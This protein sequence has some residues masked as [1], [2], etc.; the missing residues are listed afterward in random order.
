M[1][2]A[3]AAAGRRIGNSTLNT[4]RKRHQRDGVERLEGRVLF[5][6]FT[7]N[8]TGGDGLWTT[9]ANW[10]GGNAPSG[11]GTDALVFPAIGSPGTVTNDFTAGTD[12]A[13]ISFTS[14][15]YDITGNALDIGATGISNSSGTNAF[16]ANITL[17]AGSSVSASGTA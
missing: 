11:S 5:A 14:G 2:K 13:S 17:L 12:F 4:V 7:W 16:S 9:G 10:N 15:G 8:G 6:T 1:G 3:R